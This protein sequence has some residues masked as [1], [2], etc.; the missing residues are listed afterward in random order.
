MKIFRAITLAAFLAA[1]TVSQ[2]AA[3]QTRTGTQTPAGPAAPAVVPDSKIALIDSS[4]FADEKL[5]IVRLVNAIKRVD[6]EFQP[7]QTELQTLKQQLDKATADYNR[8]SPMQDPKLNQQQAD[9]IEQMDKDLK[10]KAEDAQANYQKRMGEALG[11]ISDEI[12]KALDTYAKA[13]GITL[14]LDVTKFQG[15][16][17]ADNSLDITKSF[18]AEFNSKNPATASLTP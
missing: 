15:I 13:R 10:R 11:P 16:V 18:I 9:K 6:T 17:S 8:V 7:R 3:Q 1:V 14:V 2:V 12:S 4:M 5:G